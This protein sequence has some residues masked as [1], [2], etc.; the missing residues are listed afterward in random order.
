MRDFPSC[1]GEN[2][3]Q[4]ADA[5]CSSVGLSKASQ[6]LVTCIYKCKL[7]GK[8]YLINIIWSKNMMGQCL[9]IEIE[10]LY[11][12]CLCK[13]DVKPSLF[14]KRKGSKC[15]EVYSCKIEVFWDLSLAKFGSGP[16]PVEGYYIAIVCKMEM[17]LV[18]GDLR[19]EAFK[20]TSSI[21][22]F[23]SAILVSRREH[24]FGKKVYVTKAQ[25]SDNGK[26][27]D[28]KIECDGSNDA[29]LV[30]RIDTKPVM[31]VKNLRWKFRGNYTI[32][33]DGL[34]VE[35]FWDVHNWLFGPGLGNA[36]FMFQTCWSAENLWSSQTLSD[37][38]IFSLS[39]SD[40]FMQSKLPGPSFSLFLYAW[41]NE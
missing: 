23:S 20:K 12:N 17:V 25:F 34:P 28:V 11:H 24:I 9:T 8:S 13:V 36:V 4:V 37:H 10:D 7:L 33:V 39:C 41:K 32:L 35:I 3:V 29:C 19:K 27:H 30:I 21:P 14:T 31:Q 18:I 22:S 1:F 16:E 6:N 38:S 5:S 26:V 15:L 2:G 40:S